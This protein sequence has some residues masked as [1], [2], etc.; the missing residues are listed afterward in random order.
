MKLPG[1]LELERTREQD[2][3]STEALTRT[4][5]DNAESMRD[6]NAFISLRSD[7]ALDDAREVDQE[8]SE[9]K[10]LPLAGLMLA[11]KDNIAVM[12]ETL[13]CASGTL[14]GFRTL[15]E[16]TVVSRLK[17]AGA[18]VIGK[19][20]LDEFA[21][22]SSN[23]HT[24]FGAVHN[25]YDPDRVPGGSSG[26]SAAAVAAGISQ[27]ALG[28]ETGGSVRQPAAFCG[29]VGL[30]PTYGRLSRFG[31]VAF[32]S[33]LDGIGILGQTVPDV[34]AVLEAAAGEDPM[35]STSSPEPVSP[36]R[37]HLDI[38]VEGL[39]IGVPREYL[40]EGV[41]AGIRNAFNEVRHRMELLGMV[42][43]D[44]SLPHTEYAIPTYYIIA[45]AEASS[46]LA[47]YDG[48]RYGT[49]S[50]GDVELGEMVTQSRTE[51]FGAEV[52]RRIMLGT[53]VL[54]AG[55]YEAYYKRAQRV[56]RLIQNDFLE[57]FESVDAIFAPTTPT[58][59]FLIGEKVDDPLEMYLSDIYTAPA[60][61]AGIPAVS[62][63]VNDGH[64][65]PIG[66]QI[67][68]PHFAEEVILRIAH[69]LMTR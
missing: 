68:G 63:P 2:G 66:L 27:V 61:L 35:D 67:I 30:K 50:R 52:K 5:L 39:K 32:A 58:P 15:F 11:V 13:T 38:P 14:K 23:E 40:G 33:S 9:G 55:Y 25:P 7:K 41:D 17:A 59:A 22:G 37:K 36:Y 26:G 64:E 49:R 43:Q 28:S 65:L 57:A 10:Q 53:Y 48:A 69:H 6:L 3:F 34:A 16:S 60:N 8:R 47:R 31:L 54:S 46:N 29:V 19:T 45:T 62:F 12:G 21:M 42:V 18:V 44:I 56:R 4:A 51:G 20:N 24:I 1:I